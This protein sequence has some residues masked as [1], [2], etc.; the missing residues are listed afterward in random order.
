MGSDLT[1]ALFSGAELRGDGPG[2]FVARCDPD[3]VVGYGLGDLAALAAADVLDLDDALELSTVREQL[4]AR[5]NAERSGGLLVVV[6]DDA[7]AAARSIAALSG[8]RIARHD[9][10][11]RVVLA[12]TH[13]QLGHA[14]MA[15][16]EIYV[17]VEDVDASGPLHC[18]AMADA[19]RGFASALAPVTFRGAARPVY[20]TVTAGPMRDDPRAEL[21]A[22]LEQPVLWR[23]TI[24]ALHAGGTARYVESGSGRALGGLVLETL[25]GAEPTDLESELLHAR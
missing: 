11:R 8:A 18:N 25:A 16:D 22:G 21:A 3:V 15:A 2:A 9:S 17:T 1:A 24:L 19:A 20:S 12:G 13:E 23:Q 7:A 5:A 6:D 4:I 10:P 14:R